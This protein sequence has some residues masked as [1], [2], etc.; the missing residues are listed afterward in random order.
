MIQKTISTGL[1]GA[2]ILT[3]TSGCSAISAHHRALFNEPT[4]IAAA[5]STGQTDDSISGEWRVTFHVHEMK[6]PATFN[7]KLDGTRITGT[8]YSEHTGAGTIREGQWADGKLTLTLDFAKHESIVVTGTLQDG[9]L[10]GEFKTE[11]FTDKWEA[12]KK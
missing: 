7:F 1:L 10:V 3:L 2:F 11:G 4:H 12:E 9:K 6:V 5:R 8:A